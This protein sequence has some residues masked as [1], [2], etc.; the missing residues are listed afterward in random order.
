M[1]PD[2][3]K[4][5]K[6]PYLDSCKELLGY[7]GYVFEKIDGSLVQVRRTETEIL[8]G[9]KANYITGSSRPGWSSKF[10]NWMYSNDSL[11]NLPFNL[12]MF[13]EWLEPVTVEYNP[14]SLDKF[15]FIDLALVK[16]SKPHFFDYD[17]A[18]RYLDFWNIKGI[19]VLDPLAR[20]FFTEVGIDKLRDESESKLGS[21]DIEGVVLKNYRLQKSAKSLNPKYSEI[22]DQGRKIEN[23]V[24]GPRINKALRRL[25]DDGNSNNPSLD[26][27][28]SEV[29]GDIR[30]ES[31]LKFGNITVK[32]II[33][34]K[35]LYSNKK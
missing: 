20:G 35:S 2:F 9:S 18:R 15:Y 4:Y 30:S 8:G 7:D 14:E 13:G 28:V 1:T 26:E 17:E 3:V 6:I 21:S 29:S 22:R 33:R 23:Y 16:G 25:R 12:I 31:D 19:E 11:H 27:L 32:S 5:P 34:V 10:L 24:N